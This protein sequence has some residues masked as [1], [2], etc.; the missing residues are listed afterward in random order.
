MDDE[1]LR[2]LVDMVDVECSVTRAG[3]ESELH[4]LAAEGLVRRRQRPVSVGGGDK[5]WWW[6]LTPRG[7]EAAAAGSYR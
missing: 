7:R 6:E 4:R 3:V 1:P 2:L 5:E